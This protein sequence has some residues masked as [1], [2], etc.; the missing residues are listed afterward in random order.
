MIAF[1]LV[2]L[3]QKL[4][5]NIEDIEG[6]GYWECENSKS[7]VDI[8]KTTEICYESFGDPEGVWNCH[9]YYFLI[10]AQSLKK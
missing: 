3:F 10:Q 5:G 1:E 4:N 9:Q 6:V 7:D 2:D 8:K